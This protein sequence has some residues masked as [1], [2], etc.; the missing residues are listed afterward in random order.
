MR[1]RPARPVGAGPLDD[2]VTEALRAVPRRD[3]LPG[4]VRRRA[5]DDVALPLGHGQT[6]SQPTTVA[7][8]LRLLDVRPGQGVLDV[9]SGSGW[10][11]ALLAHLVGPD[12]E[13]LGLEL[14]PAL[15]AFGSANVAARATPWARVEAA[16]PEHLG[17]ARPG[18]WDRI[19]VSASPDA[20]PRA[21]V[22]QLAPGGRLVV[23]VRTTMVLLE[24]DRHG[25]A[26][27]SEHG[28]Y[29]FVPLRGP[30]A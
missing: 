20:L 7:A 16:D 21:L 9:G 23:P 27:A 28:S 14:E 30:L 15:V 3:F 12:G 17:R 11:T 13:V 2:A 4:D 18:G 24:V 5:S 29:S 22:R 1:S 8:M 25:R 19:L 10:T 26:H 6:G